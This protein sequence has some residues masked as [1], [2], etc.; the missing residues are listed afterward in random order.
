MYIEKEHLQKKMV[1]QGWSR[2]QYFVPT[3]IGIVDVHGKVYFRDKFVEYTSFL[4]TND[5]EVKSEIVSKL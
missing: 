3:G 2:E 1:K 5:W 4:N